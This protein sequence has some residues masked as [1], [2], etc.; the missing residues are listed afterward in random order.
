[1]IDSPELRTV[2]ERVVWF[3]DADETLHYPKRFLAYLMTY[4]T[5][6]EIV[7]ARNYF[8]DSEFEATLKDPPAGIFD[9]RSWCYWNCV[10][11]RGLVPP[12]PKRRIPGVDPNSIPDLFPAK[13]QPRR[14]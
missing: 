4:G 13:S 1:M 6:E 9:P 14:G 10:Y 5:W 3:E 8:P 7:V 2:A 11:R 12:L